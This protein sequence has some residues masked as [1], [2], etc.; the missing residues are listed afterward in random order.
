M[1]HVSDSFLETNVPLLILIDAA[2]RGDEQQV[3]QYAQLFQEH[4]NKLVE[5]GAPSLSYKCTWLITLTKSNIS[6]F[7]LQAV[8]SFYM[9][10]KYLGGMDQTKVDKFVCKTAYIEDLY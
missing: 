1:D 5:V 7:S 3:E 8:I 4:A 2:K 6:R 9:S 10:V